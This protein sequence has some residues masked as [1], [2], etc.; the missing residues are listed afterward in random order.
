[1]ASLKVWNVTRQAPLAED[2][3]L[4]ADPMSR[5]VGLLGKKELPQGNGLV[6]RPCSSIHMFGMRFAVDALYV[7]SHDR[8]IQAVS[9]LAP[10]HIGPIDARAEYVIELPAGTIAATQTTIGDRLSLDLQKL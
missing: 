10:W 2:A 1:M 5:L 6:L 4:A 3:R 8:V 9:A 7:D